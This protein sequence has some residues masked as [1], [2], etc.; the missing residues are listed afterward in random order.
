[1]RF[2][3]K[4]VVVTGGARSIGR[5]TAERFAEEGASVAILDVLSDRGAEAAEAISD[6]HKVPC[7]FYEC[8]V[9]T[10]AAVDQAIDQVISDLGRVDVLFSNAGI[11]R[12]ADFLDLTEEDFDEVIR[13]NL[14]SI[15]LVGQKVARHMVERG[16]GG[17]IVNMSSSSVRMTMPT[18]AS[19]AASKG[20]ITALTNAMAL[21]LAGHGIRVNAV[22]PGTIRTELNSDN[23]LKDV[24]KRR[25]ILSRIPLM[26]F[27]DG[28]DVANVVL[29]LASDDAGYMTGE[30]IY[31]DGGRSGLNYNLVVEEKQTP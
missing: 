21:S 17:A 13:V 16:K 8:D 11:T 23:L 9:G 24:E 7:R 1:M 19:Y 14:K 25:E 15:Y 20:G 4:R 28:R 3:D 29:F 31:I 27:G 30:T 5:A 22:G 18:I 26:R 2:K 12:R 6:K 10:K